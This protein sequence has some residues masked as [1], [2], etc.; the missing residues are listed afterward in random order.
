MPAKARPPQLPE[1]DQFGPAMMAVKNPK[2]RAFIMAYVTLT[3]GNAQE[4]MR[5]AGYEDKGTGALRV[6]GCRL[7]Q[8]QDILAALREVVISRISADLPVYV[9]TLARVAHADGHKDQ[10]KALGMLMSRGGL[11]E[12]TQRDVNVNVTITTE[13]KVAEIRQMAEDLGL[14]P[15]KLLGNVTDAEFSEVVEG[16]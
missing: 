2:H 10:V 11:P 5:V 12:I 6:L 13:Q 8:R 4:A 16:E 14:D 7:L 9:S 3:N 1:T 15:A